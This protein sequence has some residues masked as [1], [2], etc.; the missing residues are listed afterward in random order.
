M[1]PVHLW[2]PIGR[3]LLVG[4]V[5]VGLSGCGDGPAD[6]PAPDPDEIAPA[7]APASAVTQ[8]EAAPALGDEQLDFATYFIEGIGGTPIRLRNGEWEDPQNARVVTLTPTP[9]LRGDLDGDGSE[10][11]AA[12]LVLGS[13]T[14]VQ[15]HLVA[16]GVAAGRPT[17]EAILDL[18]RNATVRSM[19]MDGRA[20]VLQVFWLP[21]PG[22]PP[23]PP[24]EQ[25]YLLDQERWTR[26]EG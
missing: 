15:S 8:V 24:E 10:E 22:R 19:R 2:F 1:T 20:L 5:L 3:A 9:R 4:S 11:V 18:G 6:L 7:P 12:I 14:G 26:V 13:P 16:M 23:S 25:R 21:S 17:Q